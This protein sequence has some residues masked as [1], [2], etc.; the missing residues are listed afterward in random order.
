MNSSFLTKLASGVASI[1]LFVLAT[2]TAH[3]AGTASLNI[4]GGSY[5]AGSTFTS[6]IRE[7]ST[8]GVGGVEANLTYDATKLECLG[9]SFAGS[10]FPQEWAPTVCGG[11]SISINHT[12]AFGSPAVTGTQT[13]AVVSF[14]ALAGSGNSTINFS[15]SS[16]IVNASGVNVWDGNTAGA[17]YA[18]T[19]APV[20]TPMPT[21]APKATAAPTAKPSATPTV[22]AAA[23]TEPTPEVTASPTPME[24]Q[25]ETEPSVVPA[26]QA[27]DSTR[28][29]SNVTIGSIIAVIVAGAAALYVV[30]RMNRE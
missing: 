16:K 24:G 17:G 26:P 23:T 12:V 9:V 8:E 18:F 1:S 25:V 30:R 13:V 10:A 15:S 29:V 11:G 2:G 5:Q 22:M 14:R 21:A 6:T 7:T 19:S 28:S 3:A 4:N 27:T 20:A